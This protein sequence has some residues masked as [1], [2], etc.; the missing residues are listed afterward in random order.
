MI[1][2]LRSHF[3]MKLLKMCL[4]GCEDYDDVLIK[5]IQHTHP[6][7]VLISLLL[8]CIVIV[9]RRQLISNTVESLT[10]ELQLNRNEWKN[11]RIKF[12]D[13]QTEYWYKLSKGS[14]RNRQKINRIMNAQLVGHILVELKLNWLASKVCDLQMTFTFYMIIR[15]V[16]YYYTYYDDDDYYYYFLRERIIVSE[17]DE[18]ENTAC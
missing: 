9:V 2:P 7:Y 16:Y 4:C 10:S 12:Y 11:E 3:F 15:L 1:L 8:S 5:P 6:A 14:Q 18:R 13:L 17:R